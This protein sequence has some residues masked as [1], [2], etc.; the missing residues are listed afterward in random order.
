M[1]GGWRKGEGE[2]ARTG[3]GRDGE[4]VHREEGRRQGQG[5]GMRAEGSGGQEDREGKTERDGGRET[6][7]KEVR[8]LERR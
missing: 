7:E 1:R 8:R 6:M 3:A 4:E 5:S 2:A